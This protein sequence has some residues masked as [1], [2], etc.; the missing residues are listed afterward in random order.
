MKSLSESIGDRLGLVDTP[1]C[2]PA[3]CGGAGRR[4]R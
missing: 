4:T 1:G 2:V 3:D